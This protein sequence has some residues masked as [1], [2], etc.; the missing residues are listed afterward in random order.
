[1]AGAMALLGE[2]NCYF[3]KR[4]TWPHHIHEVLGLITDLFKE[5]I[6]GLSDLEMAEDSD[7][8]RDDGIAGW[9]GESD[10]ARDGFGKAEVP[11]RQ[12]ASILV[13]ITDAARRD[14]IDTI[15]THWFPRYEPGPSI[16]RASRLELAGNIAALSW[17]LRG[18]RW[19]EAVG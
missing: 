10:D 7:T 9:T 1:M 14:V 11:W 16:L 12:I 17:L 15:F 19:L 6:H 2:L 18:R 13:R 8:I 5:R 3:V 4:R